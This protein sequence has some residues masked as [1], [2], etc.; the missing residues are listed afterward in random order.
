[1]VILPCMAEAR[2][3]PPEALACQ[4]HCAPPALSAALPAV[5]DERLWLLL[6]QEPQ[7]YMGLSHER[8]LAH[9]Y[10]AA[11]RHVR[12]VSAYLQMAA[13]NAD[14]AQQASLQ[15]AA[16]EMAATAEILAQRADVGPEARPWVLPVFARAENALAADHQA[17]ASRALVEG[18]AQ[19][20]GHYLS[21]SLQHLENASQWAGQEPSGLA[22]GQA[23][24]LM[25]ERMILGQLDARGQA[26]EGVDWVRGEVARLE[27]V[28]G[29]AA[30]PAGSAWVP[31][32]ESPNSR[33]RF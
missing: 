5:Q 17:K 23:W 15:R 28:L 7:A 4:A 30:S 9:D 19:V 8:L 24:R 27:R 33:L 3:I 6:M 32:T 11:A 12:R 2:E 18:K 14:I 16:E 26:S 22:R 1:M 21:A 31:A 13:G 20:A 10:P 25:A 29:A